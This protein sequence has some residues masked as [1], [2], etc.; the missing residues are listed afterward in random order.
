MTQ[1]Y[2]LRYFDIRGRGEPLRIIF[3]YAGVEFEDERIQFPDFPSI[4][5]TLPLGFLPVITTPNG[6]EISQ[7]LATIMYLGDEF[8]LYGSGSEQRAIINC[9]LISLKEL[10]DDFANITVFLKDEAEKEKTRKSLSAKVQ[11]FYVF[12]E[13]LRSENSSSKYLV[14]DKPTIADL[15]FFDTYEAINTVLPGEDNINKFPKL[16][17]LDEDV[18]NLDSVKKYLETR[19]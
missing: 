4:K 11:V 9:C 12:L 15:Y 16:K 10:H 7:T 1:Q 18:R 17:K 14:G 13:K 2:K 19:K 8:N 6:V 5:P 3:H